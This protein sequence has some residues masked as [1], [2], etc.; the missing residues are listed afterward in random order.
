M[1]MVVP[2]LYIPVNLIAAMLVLISGWGPRPSTPSG[3]EMGPTGYL[4]CGLFGT[5]MVPVALL[6]LIEGN[7]ED[8]AGMYLLSYALFV[9]AGIYAKRR[10]RAV[11]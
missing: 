4:V 10:A 5:L 2:I 6:Y 9:G 1:G 8:V 11:H 7:Y 3:S